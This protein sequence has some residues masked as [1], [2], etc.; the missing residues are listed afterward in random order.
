MSIGPD[1]LQREQT[2]TIGGSSVTLDTNSILQCVFEAV[3]EV[4]WARRSLGEC[5]DIPDPVMRTVLTYSY[6]VGIVS[7]EDLEAAAVHEPIVRYL[8]ARHFPDWR[9]IREFRRR[10]WPGLVES[11][12]LVFRKVLQRASAVE[13]R[14]E[15][16]CVLTR[17]IRADSAAMDD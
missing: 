7:S 13:M 16:E 10:N 2:L 15:A 1:I 3:H 9:V 8:C 12:A 14:S 4:Q 5:A 6:V 17:A 11:I